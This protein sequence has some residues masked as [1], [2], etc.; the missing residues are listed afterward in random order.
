MDMPKDSLS[1]E[2]F[3][4]PCMQTEP[5]DLFSSDIGTPID[6]NDESSV[7]GWEQQDILCEVAS[8]PYDMSTSDSQS[9]SNDLYSD[10][11]AF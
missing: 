6:W 2:P 11:F 5:L 4:N 7:A 9:E 1:F 8:N 3:G 10:F